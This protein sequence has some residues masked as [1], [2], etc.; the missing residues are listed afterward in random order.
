MEK[1]VSNLEKRVALSNRLMVLGTLI[2]TK[3]N[4]GNTD[5]LP[6]LVERYKKLQAELDRL[7]AES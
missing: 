4:T 1:Q 3:H 6:E 5:G 7:R 2:D